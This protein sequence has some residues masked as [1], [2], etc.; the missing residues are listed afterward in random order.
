MTDDQRPADPTASARSKIYAA[1]LGMLR[2]QLADAQPAPGPY[3]LANAGAA[4]HTAVA[5]LAA[6]RT[7]ADPGD[8]PIAV[9]PGTPPADLAE[10]LGTLAEVRAAVELVA[11][12]VGQHVSR[13][14]LV[15]LQYGV[16]G[17][18]GS[19]PSVEVEAIMRVLLVAERTAPV[20][21]ESYAGAAERLRRLSLRPSDPP[22]R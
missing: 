20:A 4:L 13:L 6:A 22:G 14:H 18:P 19:T 8:V 2:K 7:L 16:A 21:A 17:P 12:M 3:D 15:A 9:D 1:R 5:A 11:F 10:L